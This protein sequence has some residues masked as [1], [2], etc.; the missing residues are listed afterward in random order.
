MNCFWA[1]TGRSTQNMQGACESVL[2]GIDSDAVG[3]FLIGSGDISGHANKGYFASGVSRQ[4]AGCQKLKMLFF[5][6]HQHHANM[7]FAWCLSQDG[8]AGPTN[9]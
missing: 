1:A 9:D 3:G 4:G 7:V 2:P 8:H 5:L 6:M